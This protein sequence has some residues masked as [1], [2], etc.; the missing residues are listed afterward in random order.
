MKKLLLI[1]L[2]WSLAPLSGAEKPKPSNL[3]EGRNLRL[4]LRLPL[5]GPNQVIA[6]GVTYTRPSSKSATKPKPQVKPKPKTQASGN[7]LIYDGIK[8]IG[9]T[10][11]FRNKV[12][13]LLKRIENEAPL[14]YKVTKKE[15]VWFKWG[16]KGSYAYCHQ[17]KIVLG[18]RDWKYSRNPGG[19]GWFLMTMIH[20]IQHCNIAGDENED[21]AS[22]AAYHYG[23]QMG[24]RSFLTSF[25]KGWATKRGYSPQKWADNIRRTTISL[26]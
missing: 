22:W 25:Q 3:S 13:S 10:E 8:I 21:G 12:V 2:I 26:R 5:N 18:A 11:E 6:N 1:S 9:G 20:E 4:L 7:T 24:V 14:H 15:V 19:K 17:G 16:E 23:K